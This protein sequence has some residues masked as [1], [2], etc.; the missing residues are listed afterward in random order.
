M[1]TASA[2]WAEALAAWAIPERI[3]NAAPESPWG[4]PPGVFVAVAR[5]ALDS[6]WTPTHRRAA[7]VLPPGGVVLDV[8]SGAGAAS[9]P[10]APPAG[11]IVAVDQ[12][13][14]MLRA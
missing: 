4:F 9:L 3:L 1:T 5:A 14:E 6:P 11:R 12:D 2:R 8:G 13:I 10:V 7:E